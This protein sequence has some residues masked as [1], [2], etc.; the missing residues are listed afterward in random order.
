M[1]L[2]EKCVSAGIFACNVWR[3]V[4]VIIQ[5]DRVVDRVARGP[6]GTDEKSRFT[7]LN[8]TPIRLKPRS[9]QERGTQSMGSR[10]SAYSLSILEQS[11]GY[12]VDLFLCLGPVMWHR[13]VAQV[14]GNKGH[15]T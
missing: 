10:G 8:I 12:E 15:C 7:V 9:S 11:V 4:V 13:R 5:N 3:V 2:N 14:C 6:Y 1:Q